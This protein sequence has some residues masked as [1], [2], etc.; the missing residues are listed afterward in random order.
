[1]TRIALIA[2][3]EVEPELKAWLESIND[4]KLSASDPDILMDLRFLE[5]VSH[6]D[7]A[8]KAPVVITSLL[9]S[10]V[11]SRT[12]FYP[13]GTKVIGAAIL[14]L[15]VSNQKVIEC[16]IPFGSQIS[17]DEVRNVFAKLGKE[18]EVIGDAIGGVFPRTIAMI[19]NE[20]AFALQENVASA[21]DIDAAMKLG[22][23]Y[24]VGPLALCDEIG[25]NT[26]IAILEALSREFGADR[27]RPAPLLRRYAEAN[28]QFN[29]AK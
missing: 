29:P 28:L 2:D 9:T 7:K 23:N 11:T 26:V 4:I 13:V 1:M 25:A 20:A 3:S 22:T 21:S 15:L 27:Y 10:A 19:I 6:I 5:Q 16:A 18:V 14:P 24:P 12:N 8:I 17:Q